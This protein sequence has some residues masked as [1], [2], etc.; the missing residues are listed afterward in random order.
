MAVL[1]DGDSSTKPDPAAVSQPHQSH[2]L[3]VGPL[4]PAP[5]P[6]DEPVQIVC[7]PPRE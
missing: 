3:S 2:P 4:S 5:R 6:W 1:R 7:D